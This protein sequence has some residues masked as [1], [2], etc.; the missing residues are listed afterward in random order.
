MKKFRLA[1]AALLLSVGAAHAQSVPN[2]TVTQGLS[3]QTTANLI[4][5]TASNTTTATVS[6]TTVTGDVIAFNCLGF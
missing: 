6:G 1:L 2:G 4:R 5:Q 3:N